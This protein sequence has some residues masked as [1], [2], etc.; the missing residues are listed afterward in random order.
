MALQGEPS[1]VLALKPFFFGG[2]LNSGKEILDFHPQSPVARF[3]EENSE[4]IKNFLFKDPHG[5]RGGFG[6]STA[7]FILAWAYQRNFSG[8]LARERIWEL[9][10]FYRKYI[11]RG[12]GADLVAQLQ[13]GISFFGP[14]DGL[15]ESHPWPFSEVDFLIIPTGFK[16]K[17]HEHLQDLDINNLSLNP[18]RESQQKIVN[19]IL[20]SSADEL[21]MGVRDWE[22][23]TRNLNL[24][25]RESQESI[26]LLKSRHPEIL[27]AKGCGALGADVLLLLVGKEKMPQV[28]AS[29]AGRQEG[30]W[31][32]RDIGHGLREV[33]DD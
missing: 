28:C 33:L 20:T 25:C 7:E 16:V 3:A 29:L 14:N 31:S 6:G 21:I 2:N 15:M 17:T 18:L 5:G 22:K 13:G 12:S 10:D 19:S 9:R 4:G 23:A 24:L 27:A 8:T 11:S 1:L 30:L 32:S 26:D